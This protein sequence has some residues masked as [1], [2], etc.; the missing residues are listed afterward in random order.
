[1]LQF[2]SES[3]GF[4]RLPVTEW[5]IC[6][7]S[8]GLREGGGRPFFDP[9]GGAWWSIWRRWW[10]EGYGWLLDPFFSFF[11]FPLSSW[12]GI[13]I[14]FDTIVPLLV[15]L[16][17]PFFFFFF[18]WRGLME[19]RF[20]YNN[21]LVMWAFWEA[22]CGLKWIGHGSSQVLL[23]NQ[24]NVLGNVRP[25]LFFLSIVVGHLCL[26]CFYFLQ[27]IF[28]L[29]FT[30]PFFKGIFHLGGWYLERTL[31]FTCHLQNGSAFASLHLLNTIWDYEYLMYTLNILLLNV[32]GLNSAVKRTCVLE[33]YTVNLF[34]VPWYVHCVIGYFF[35]MCFGSVLW[36]WICGCM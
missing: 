16:T 26:C 9:A 17:P 27:Q 8:T 25:E 2:S 14:L 11:F 23:F 7:G 13:Y 4:C 28:M 12:D 18:F 34:L 35:S 6:C 31:A 3:G 1:M 15:R 32:T 10:R 30:L 33:Y 21:V 22:R 20:H 29:L 36:S 24:T 5:D 19:S